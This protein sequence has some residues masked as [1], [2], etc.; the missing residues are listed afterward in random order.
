MK[1]IKLT[2]IVIAGL[3]IYILFLQECSGPKINIGGSGGTLDTLKHTTDT[4]RISYTDTI[5]LPADT[6]YVN[7]Y[8]TTPTI[9]YDTIQHNLLLI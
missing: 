3:L 8:N 9:L 1:N 2:Y 7:I 5:T 4:V 6:H